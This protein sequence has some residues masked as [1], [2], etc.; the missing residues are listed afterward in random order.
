MAILER[1]IKMGAIAAADSSRRQFEADVDMAGQVNRELLQQ[2]LQLNQNS[3][4]GQR[5]RFDR[6]D[7]REAVKEALPLTTYDDYQLYIERIAAGE[8]NVLTSEPVKHFSLTSGTTGKQKMIPMTARADRIISEH[9]SLLSHGILFDSIPAS[10]NLNRGLNIMK[11]VTAPRPLK[12]AADASDDAG[13]PF[14]D[15]RRVRLDGHPAEPARLCPASGDVRPVKHI[16]PYL[17]TSPPEVLQV[18]N[19]QDANYL[20]LL[21]AL[22]ERDLMYICSPFSSIVADLFQLL[23]QAWPQLVDNLASGRI[24][25]KGGLDVAVKE[26]LERKL[27][28][29]PERARELETELAK[30]CQNITR[31]IW[32]HLLYVNCVT[33]GSFSIYTQL[34]KHYIDGV[35]IYSGIYS[36][37]EA[38][39]GISLWPEEHTYVVTPRTA[40]HEFIPLGQINETRPDVLDLDQLARGES[41][42]VVITNC[43]GLYRYR[44]GDIVKVVDYYKESP[45]IE[46]LYRRGQLIDLVGEKTSEQVVSSTV[47][48]VLRH[49]DTELVD[50]TTMVDY[51]S[52]PCRYIFYVEIRHSDRDRI[53]GGDTLLE[54]ALCR[55][56]PRYQAIRNADNLG[57]LGLRVVQPGTFNKL[58]KILI[59]RGASANQVQVPRVIRDS[60]ISSLLSANTLGGGNSMPQA[61]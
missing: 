60:E 24:D 19:Q 4:Y 34:L 33:G 57:Q 49:L 58:K 43:A 7:T 36:A 31:R 55:V 48:Q 41:Y 5:F 23:E 61:G 30:G 18:S 56:N 38:M 54:E 35:P 21:F 16:S 10:R 29:N 9:M 1:A 39:V 27:G 59:G 14:E 15:R 32:P 12:Q 17:W 44:L 45:V 46:F 42:E 40:Y 8:T 52:Y 20:H 53:G 25:I 26:S 13:I 37:T 28:N 3:D 51:E 6:I 22:A 11:A 47:I 50:F 2:I